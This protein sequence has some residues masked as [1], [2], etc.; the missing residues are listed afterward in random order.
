MWVIPDRRIESVITVRDPGD[1]DA[2]PGAEPDG[3]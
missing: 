2:E 1:P 3:S